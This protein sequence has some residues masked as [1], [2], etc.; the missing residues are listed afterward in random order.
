M[1]I[2]IFFILSFAVFVAAN[3]Q[4]AD[5]AYVFYVEM[6][7]HPHVQFPRDTIPDSSYKQAD[8]LKTYAVRFSSDKDSVFI[9]NGNLIGV[10]S[11]TSANKI[12]YDLKVFAG[13]RFVLWYNTVP[14]QAELT[15]YGSGVPIIISERGPL[16]SS[17]VRAT[18]P[19]HSP[20]SG[21]GVNSEIKVEIS[22]DGRVIRAFHT[23]SLV[24]K[25]CSRYLLC[26]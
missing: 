10:K 20:Q 15:I 5:T 18:H 2:K 26:F 12:Q 1:N 22:A 14:Y 25:K 19:F 21:I 13:G 6:V 7:A 24:S 16:I 23:K 8:S 9:N 3:A 17:S 4:P 11:S